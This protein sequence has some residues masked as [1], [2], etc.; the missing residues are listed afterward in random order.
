MQ[1]AEVERLSSEKKRLLQQLEIA[2][3]TS[4]ERGRSADD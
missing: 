2:W 4:A 3:K 1:E